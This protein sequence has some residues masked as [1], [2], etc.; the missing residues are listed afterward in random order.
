MLQ[1]NNLAGHTEAFIAAGVDTCDAFRDCTVEELDA[2]LHRT[3]HLMLPVHRRY[4]L[5]LH[6]SLR[7]PCD[8][9]PDK[10]ASRSS[11]ALSHAPHLLVVSTVVGALVTVKTGVTSLVATCLRGAASVFFSNLARLLRLILTVVDQRPTAAA[12]VVV[13]A[14]LPASPVATAQSLVSPTRV[15]TR[16]ASANRANRLRHEQRLLDAATRD[17]AP[18]QAL[19]QHAQSELSA[20]LQSQSELS[21]APPLAAQAQSGGASAQRACCNS[22]D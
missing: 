8:S 18:P 17:T 5:A 19:R 16:F 12:C 15:L 14:D 7:P 3:S 10:P 11:F 21:A 4:M 13:E 22:Y 20:A 9:T 1:T 2:A 6:K